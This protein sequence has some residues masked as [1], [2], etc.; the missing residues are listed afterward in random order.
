[1]ANLIPTDPNL[2]PETLAEAYREIRTL[3]AQIRQIR[4]IA[5]DNAWG[6]VLGICNA[7]PE[8]PAEVLRR[9]CVE[10][11]QQQN[12]EVDHA[13]FDDA[14]LFC[15]QPTYKIG[16]DIQV[17]YFGRWVDAQVVGFNRDVVRA[18]ISGQALIH[19]YHIRN[20]RPKQETQP[21]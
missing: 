21:A 9:M 11:G 13:V 15:A 3:R 2:M 19:S 6:E 1:M 18:L 7:I 16:D 17:K 8:N 20:T 14:A 10:I 12:L 5:E 4:K